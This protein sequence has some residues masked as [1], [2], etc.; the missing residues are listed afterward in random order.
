VVLFLKK[1]TVQTDFDDSGNLD[2]EESARN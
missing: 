1:K 2:I